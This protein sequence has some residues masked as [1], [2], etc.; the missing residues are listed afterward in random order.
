MLG[1]S[2]MLLRWRRVCRRRMTGLLGL[3]LMLR[4]AIGMRVLRLRTPGL[5][6]E[7]EHCREQHTELDS[8]FHELGNFPFRF[9]S[10]YIFS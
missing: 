10:D 6:R 3:G 7:A 1:R 2:G 9:L 8:A 5:A 4:R